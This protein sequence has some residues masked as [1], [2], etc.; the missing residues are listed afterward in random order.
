MHAAIARTGAAGEIAASQTRGLAGAVT[1]LR[2]QAK[3]TGQ[4]LYTAAAPDLK[5]VTRLMSSGV[6]AAPPGIAGALDYLHDLYTLEV[7][8][9]GG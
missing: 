5:K 8:L 6:A 1:L 7:V 2:I 9:Y 4:V 3:N